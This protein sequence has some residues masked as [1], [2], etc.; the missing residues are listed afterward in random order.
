M[1]RT[2]AGS[3]T[4]TDARGGALAGTGVLLRFALRRDGVRLPV[5]IGALTAGTLASLSSFEQTYSTDA[6]RTAIAKTLGSPAGLAMSGPGHYLDDYGLGAMMGHQMLG[7]VAVLVGLMTVLTVARHTRMEEETGRAELVR[8]AVVGRHAHLTAALVT[9]ALASLALGGL[10]AAGLGASGAEGVGWHGSLLYGAAHAAVGI[11]FAGVAA[12]TVQ[13]TQHSRGASGM[14]LAAIGAAYAL[15]AAGDVGGGALSWLSPIGWAQ[16]TYVFVD[17]RWWPLLLCLLLAAGAAA[18]GYVLSTRRD[19]GAGLRAARTGRG[20]ASGLLTRPVGFA[21]R[22]QRGLL[23]GF[24]AGLFVLG[25]MYGS[26]LGQAEEMI[27]DLAE[28]REV[29][30]QVG[31]A[32]LAE[33]FAATVMIVVAVVASVHGVMAALRPRAEETAGRAE[34][35]LATGLSRARWVGSHVAVATAG[36]VVVLLA[37]GLGFGLLG[38]AST[39]DAG[40]VPDLLGAA[41]AYA[42]ALWVTAGVGVALFGWAP[43]ATAAVWIVPVY[44][45]VVGYLG[46]ILDLPDWLAELSPFGH[47]PRVPAE[48]MDWGA[49]AGLTAVAAALVAFGIAGFRRRDLETK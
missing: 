18:A 7:F 31:D 35:L 13:V 27:E 6:D 10:L 44:A 36:G 26:I 5:W 45:F 32:S 30:R 46:P 9:A 33:S 28:L 3:A 16:R 42:P 41:L 14:A 20:S 8:A 48:S 37:A 34:P 1:E 12:V 22:Q 49:A 4:G 29:V 21:L 19:L 38:A 43:R 47:V 39:G 25:A 24:A 11:V 17:D 40:V 15:R 23:Y 2:A